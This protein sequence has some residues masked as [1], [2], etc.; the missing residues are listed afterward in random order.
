MRIRGI[1]NRLPQLPECSTSSDG[2]FLQSPKNVNI[3]EHDFPSVPVPQ[4][5]RDKGGVMTR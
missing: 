3:S 5:E 4:L 1:G 2:Q